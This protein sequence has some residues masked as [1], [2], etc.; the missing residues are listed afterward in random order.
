MEGP[1]PGTA[2]P[3]VLPTVISSGTATYPPGAIVPIDR[4]DPEELAIHKAG[5]QL[6]ALSE[7]PDLIGLVKALRRRWLLAIVGGLAFSTLIGVAVFYLLPPKHYARALVHVAEKRPRDLF[8]TRESEV[9]YRTYQETQLMLVKSRKVLEAAIAHPGVA[10]LRIIQDQGDP[11][12]WL[13]DHIKAEFPRG[14]EILSISLMGNYPPLDLPTIVNAVTDSYLNQIVEKERLERLARLSRLKELFADYQN[15]LSEKRRKIKEMA[16]SIGTNDKQTSAVR[17][18]M[19]VEHL[20]L[21]RQE[22]LRLQSDIRKSRARLTVLTTKQDVEPASNKSIDSAEYTRAAELDP[23]VVELQ[24]RL[25]ELRGRLANFRSIARKGNDASI[26]TLSQQ[27]K[28]LAEELE[29]RRQQLRTHR[30]RSDRASPPERTDSRLA[31]VEEYLDILREQE[32]SLKQEI[33]SLEAESSSLNV[34][35]MDFHWLEDEIALASDTAKMVG[36]E[37]QSMTVELQAPPRIRL[38]EEAVTPVSSDPFRRYKYSALG[39]VGTFFT[40][41]GCLSIWEFRKRK[42]DTPDEV[43]QGLGLRIIGDLPKLTAPHQD[44]LREDDRSVLLESIDAIRIMLLNASRVKVLRIVMVTSALKGEGKTSLSCQLAT[45]L[46]RSNR[47]TLLLDC[48]LHPSVQEV[49]E[50][51]MVPGLCEILRGETAWN[52][53]VQQGPVPA[54]SR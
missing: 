45:S 44:G 38:V 37:V 2:P 14:S 7:T 41:L 12:A 48:D 28:R 42:I 47:K 17:Q 26:R 39:V 46:A 8:E 27:I 23:E 9:G 19:M 30:A 53:A 52:D 36:T 1:E 34:K 32:R 31:E 43:T 5:Y 29:Q 40:F 16:G 3:I 25:T 6:L 22:L 21:A 49:F 15:D 33:E 51:P 24:S 13:A 20:G 4:N 54:V 10:E 35:S 50:F 18:Q 11:I